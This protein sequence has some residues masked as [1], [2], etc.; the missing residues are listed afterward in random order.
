MSAKIKRLQIKNHK[1]ESVKITEFGIK[2]DS[3]DFTKTTRNFEGI[4]KSSRM[5][6]PTK[7]H[8]KIKDR[9]S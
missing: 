6:Y 3:P 7:I 9:E 8:I 2:K 5:L 4:P 1:K